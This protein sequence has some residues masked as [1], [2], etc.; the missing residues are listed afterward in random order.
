MNAGSDGVRRYY[1]YR[2]LYLEGQTEPYM[3]IVVGFPERLA[4]NA[5][6]SVLF[7]NVL[8]L[9]VIVPIAALITYVVGGA[10]F[11]RYVERVADTAA[12]ISRGDLTARTDIPPS[13][14]EIGT[15]A[16]AIDKMAASLQVR[17]TEQE[18]EQQRIARS[19]QEKEVLLKEIHHRVKNNM[20]LILSI[21]H[22][23]HG[24]MTD[25]D[26]F[27]DDLEVRISAVAGVH[28]QLYQSGDLSS[29][30]MQD[31]FES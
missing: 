16:A 15:V 21:V 29:V 10:V 22:L 13:R 2:R 3:Y 12:R 6:L 9:L 1:A 11:G 14:S 26:A 8:L 23:Q 25:L 24:S 19:L 7:R 5:A 31:F 20:Q 18:R 27:C 4:I 17:R 28:E 30:M